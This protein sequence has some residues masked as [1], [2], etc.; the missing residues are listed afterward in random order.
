MHNSKNNTV[1][2]ASYKFTRNEEKTPTQATAGLDT[3]LENNSKFNSVIK[4]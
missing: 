2:A 3:H 1:V 4:L